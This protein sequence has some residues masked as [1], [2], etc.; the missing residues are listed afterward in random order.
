MSLA[1]AHVLVTGGTD[2]IGLALARRLVS[3]G[4]RLTVCGRN[5]ARRDSAREHLG[6]ATCVLPCNLA[7]LG[8]H[9][10]LLAEARAAHG[11]IDVLVNNAG[12]QQRMDFARADEVRNIAVEV[13]LN[14]TA[15]MLLTE[16][17]PYTGAPALR[18]SARRAQRRGERDG[19]GREDL[20]GSWPQGEAQA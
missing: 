13:A 7:D 6:P 15:P 17:V 9:A 8:Q 10:Q 19:S 2:G 12:T 11:P 16:A 18:E 14:R 4:A 20:A 3:E 5:Q 1:H